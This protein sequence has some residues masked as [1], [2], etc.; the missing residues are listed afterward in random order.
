ML[1]VVLAHQGGWDEMLFV[2]LPIGLFAFLLYI[3]NKRAQAQL[4][5]AADAE[6]EPEI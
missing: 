2:A 3:A 5:D 6:D 4:D 1:E